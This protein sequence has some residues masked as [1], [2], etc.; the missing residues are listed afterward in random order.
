MGVSSV[1]FAL[2][3]LCVFLSTDMFVGLAP[4]SKF[5]V[6]FGMISASR[7]SDGPSGCKI[8]PQVYNQVKSY[9]VAS[10]LYVMFL[11][12]VFKKLDPELAPPHFRRL[13]LAR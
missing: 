9:L 2:A 5:V 10:L 11:C 8:T 3:H 6:I 13:P 1:R 7:C 12:Y 4:W